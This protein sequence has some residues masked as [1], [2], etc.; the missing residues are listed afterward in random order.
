MKKIV[1]TAAIL[2]MFVF[3]IAYAGPFGPAEPVVAPGKAAVEV[4]YFRYS[5]N[6]KP[7]DNAFAGASDFWQKT[8][9]TQNQVYVQL[10]YGIK[11]WEVYGRIGM[12]DFKAADAFVF[13]ASPA[14]AKDKARFY[15]TL[16][17]KR[18]VYSS[19]P[20]SLSPFIQASYYGN[21]S[22]TAQGN[23]AGS[24][25]ELKYSTSKSWDAYAGVSGQMKLSRATLFAGPFLYVKRMKMEMESGIG[26]NDATRFREAN[27]IGGFAG[28][29][30]PVGEKMSVDLEVQYTNRLSAG[31]GLAYKF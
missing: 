2:L 7:S 18:I 31:A 10:S 20:F 11:A 26:S 16:G 27:N 25:V 19:G 23:V 6:L 1:L 15:G 17:A 28:V 8:G 12:A 9:I 13:D 3:S 29:R 30:V 14:D 22:D 4:G 5:E 24:P 21:F